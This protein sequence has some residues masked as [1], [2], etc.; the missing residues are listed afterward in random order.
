MINDP[1][2]TPLE[3]GASPSA[4]VGQGQG[5]QSHPKWQKLWEW[6]RL[7]PRTR[8]PDAELGPFGVS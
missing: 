6:L 5:G 7:R 3:F 8:V 2:S 1:A 4:V